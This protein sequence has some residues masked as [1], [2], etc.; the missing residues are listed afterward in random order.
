MAELTMR[1]S[2]HFHKG[3]ALTQHP[4]VYDVGGLPGGHTAFIRETH[5]GHWQLLVAEPG[6]TFTPR[7]QFPS[8]ERALKQLQAEYDARER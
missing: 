8:P 2:A 5:E 1:A 3:E 4:T 6:G 7:G